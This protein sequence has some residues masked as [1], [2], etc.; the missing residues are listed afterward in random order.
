MAGRKGKYTP[1]IVKELITALETGMTDGDACIIAGID[2]ST[3]Y[4]WQEAKSEF[5]DRVTRAR[6]KGWLGA[7]AVL[8]HE[9]IV[10]RDIKAACEYLDRTRSPYRKSQ[11]TVL[12]NG[13]AGQPFTFRLEVVE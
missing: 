3:F 11:E 1:E 6:P 2:E 12:S 4:R 8:K 9:A 7:L 5:R 10:N 13:E